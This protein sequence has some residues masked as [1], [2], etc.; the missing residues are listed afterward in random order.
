VER[1]LPVLPVVVA[2]V[3]DQQVLVV[4]QDQVYLLAILGLRSLMLQAALA[5]QV[6]LVAQTQG[7]AAALLILSMQTFLQVVLEL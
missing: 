5:H 4:P 3:R 1:V 6:Q 7:T 2:E